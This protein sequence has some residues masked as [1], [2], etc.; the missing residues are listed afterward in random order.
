MFRS[1]M[2][3]GAGPAKDTTCSP[4]STTMPD[5]VIAEKSARTGSVLRTARRPST[6]PTMSPK[7]SKMGSTM[8]IARAGEPS[9]RRSPTICASSFIK[10][11]SGFGLSRSLLASV[12]LN[13]ARSGLAWSAASSLTSS[14]LLVAPMTRNLG[15][16]AMMTSILAARLAGSSASLIATV[17]RDWTAWPIS[18][19][20][21]TT[22]SRR[23]VS[24]VSVSSL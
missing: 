7:S 3:S 1:A 19:R 14:S 15:S 12:A 10:A 17:F 21:A 23:A 9:S 22:P 16:M 5:F 13:G 8:A 4:L 24:R 20:C 11:R 2:D 6:P 18:A